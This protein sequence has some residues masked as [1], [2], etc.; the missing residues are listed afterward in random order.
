[1]ARGPDRRAVEYLK[2]SADC[3]YFT[4]SYGQLDQPQG[5]GTHAAIPFR[6]WPAQTQVLWQLMRER[7]VLILKA[8]QLGI[9]WLLCSYAL[10]LCLFHPGRVVLLFSRGQAE[11][12]ELLRRIKALYQ[13]L[14][15]WLRAALP[16]VTTDNTAEFAFGN[17]SRVQSFPATEHA[18]RS[19]TASLVIMDEFAFMQ[20]A[21]KLYTAVKPTVDGGGQLVILSTANGKSNLFADLWE[22]A[23]AGATQFLPVFLSW[24]ARPDRDDAWMARVRADAVDP[25]LVEQ[26]YP[27]T[28]EQAFVSTDR[29]RFLPSITWWDDCR[30]ALPPLGRDEPIVLAADAGVS[31]DCFSLVAVSGWRDGDVGKVAVRGVWNWEPPPGGV[32]DYD[33]IEQEIRRICER[34][35]VLQIAYDQ[36]QL[37]QMMTRL[38]TDGVAWTESFSQS[39]DRLTADRALLDA[40]KGRALVHGGHDTLRQHLDNADRKL[41]GSDTQMQRLRIV[42]RKQSLKIDGAVT[43]SM[44]H[45]RAVTDFALHQTV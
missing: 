4:D 7:Q 11:A 18:G 2:C 43:L 29:A 21:A 24:R 16:R 13:R 45:Y 15:D 6:L 38:L 23:V 34:H 30:V 8:R 42:K 22:R 20:W 3:A 9:S 44:A 27:E 40:I 12:D 33:P 14:P 37:H 28:A 31:D 36:Y 25:L 5:D 26:E 1:M 17:G 32:L 19:F 39:S 10:W 41:E 35:H